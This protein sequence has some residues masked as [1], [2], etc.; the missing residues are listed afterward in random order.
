[1]VPT[2]M[3]RMFSR[4]VARAVVNSAT[5]ASRTIRRSQGEANDVGC[6]I[7]D[8][9]LTKTSTPTSRSATQ[10]HRSSLRVGLRVRARA[11]RAKTDR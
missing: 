11:A 6:D 9:T 8:T 5:P 7:M 4:P 2:I 1:M 10:P 3:A